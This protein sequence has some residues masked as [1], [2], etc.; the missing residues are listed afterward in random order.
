MHILLFWS[1]WKI[2]YFALVIK[3][4]FWYRCGDHRRYGVLANV[5]FQVE[6]TGRHLQMR[7]YLSSLAEEWRGGLKSGVC[8]AARSGHTLSAYVA[9]PLSG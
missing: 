9:L 3:W 7:P 1:S 4:V 6:L 5:R 8:A 2:S